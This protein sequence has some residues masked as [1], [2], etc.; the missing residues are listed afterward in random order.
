VMFDLVRT[1]TT[2]EEIGDRAVFELTR[3]HLEQI[4]GSM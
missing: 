2:L 1:E 3:L 4:A